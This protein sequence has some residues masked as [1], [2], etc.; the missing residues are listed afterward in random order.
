[1]SL[2]RLGDKALRRIERTIGEPVLRG[3][4]NGGSVFGFVTP[5]HRH[6]W[7]TK[8][9][10]EWGWEATG[11]CVSSCWETWPDDFPPLPEPAAPLAPV[12]Q[13]PPP[14]RVPRWS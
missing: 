12:F 9:T 1:M 10:E 6:G 5:D 3:W 4:A 7:W 14:A 13:P 11:G 2:Q 8:R